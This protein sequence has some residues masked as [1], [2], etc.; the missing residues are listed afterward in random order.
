[1]VA[2][3]IAQI[4][5]TEEEARSIV[6]KAQER[7]HQIVEEAREEAARRQAEAISQA[8]SQAKGQ[9]VEAQT[10]ERKARDA[11]QSEID[12]ETEQLRQAAGRKKEAAVA[13]VMKE[14]LG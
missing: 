14:F 11:A 7:S 2:E 4:K 5:E 3:T 10:S 8:D 1:M 6:W 9:A 12:A 13:A